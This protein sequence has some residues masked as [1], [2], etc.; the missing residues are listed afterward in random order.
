MNTVA[1]ST[2]KEGYISSAEQ[3]ELSILLEVKF[4]FSFFIVTCAPNAV[5]KTKGKNA[6]IGVSLSLLKLLTVFNSFIFTGSM[7]LNAN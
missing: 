7:L 6:A 4:T 3:Q 2:W 1:E 5:W